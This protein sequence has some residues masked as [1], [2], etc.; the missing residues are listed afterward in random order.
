MAEVFELLCA[1]EGKHFDIND[2]IGTL[3]ELGYIP[4]GTVSCNTDADGKY[5]GHYSRVYNGKI[6][7]TCT[8]EH[9]KKIGIQQSFTDTGILEHEINYDTIIYTGYYPNGNKMS[10]GPMPNGK[11]SGKYIHWNDNKTIN[12]ICEFFDGKKHGISEIYSDIHFDPHVDIPYVIHGPLHEI[13]TY[14][15]DKRNG[16]HRV[17]YNDGKTLKFER[18]YE[19]GDRTGKETFYNPDGTIKTQMIELHEDDKIDIST[20]ELKHIPVYH[21]AAN[22]MY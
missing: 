18:E 19:N 9:G 6:V 3:T 1:L 15:N 16:I 10:Q 5:H 20:G 11:M 21:W 12:E 14:L 7:E 8:Y 2:P 13:C 17:Y 22:V 4:K